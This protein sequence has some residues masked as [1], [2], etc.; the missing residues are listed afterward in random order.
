MRFRFNF[1]EGNQYMAQVERY[2]VLLEL[3]GPRKHNSD[4]VLR[5][6]NDGLLTDEEADVLMEWVCRF[7]IEVGQINAMRT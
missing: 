1:N 4:L 6:L 5:A 3:Y 2:I 7:P